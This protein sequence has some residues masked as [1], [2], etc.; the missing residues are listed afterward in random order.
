MTSTV[1]IWTLASYTTCSFCGIQVGVSNIFPLGEGAL[2]SAPPPKA[3]SL[4]SVH[5]SRI[6]G[7][8]IDL[9]REPGARS[10]NNGKT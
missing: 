5:P 10:Q 7:I 1:P 3:C 4:G 2:F 9:T 8:G 6:L